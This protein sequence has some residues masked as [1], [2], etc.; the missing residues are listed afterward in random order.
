MSAAAVFGDKESIRA[1][2]LR[3][4]REARFKADLS[5]HQL[6]E[7]VTSLNPKFVSVPKGC[8]GIVFNEDTVFSVMALLGVSVDRALPIRG[9]DNG[10]RVSWIN[11]MKHMDAGSFVSSNSDDEVTL[12]ADTELEIF[13]RMEAIKESF[14]E[15]LSVPEAEL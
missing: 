14:H 5:P 12:E 7:M 4:I 3:E 10:V 11:R 6:C 2:I 9:L 13:L 1:N 15:E 8:S